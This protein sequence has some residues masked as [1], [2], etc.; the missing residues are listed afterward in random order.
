MRLFHKQDA[1]LLAGLSVA[2]VIIFS[3]SISRLLDYTREVER[4]HGLS[5]LPALVVLTGVFI[6]HQLRKRHEMV[7]Q[8][9]AAKAA[10]VE[11]E[12]RVQDLERLVAFGHALARA[13]N[14]DAIRAAVNQHLARLAGTDQVWVMLRQGSAWEAFTGDT[15]AAGDV[16]DREILADR[17]LGG[18]DMIAEKTDVV[19][20][21]LI[22][23]GTPI[24]VVGVNAP[25]GPLDPA[26]HRAIE[27]AGALL[28]VSL[29]NAQ[30]FEEVRNNSMRD[31][32]TGCVMR[33]HAAELIDVE[34]RRARRSQLPV[35][36]VMFDLDHFKQV[37]D[38]YGHLCGDAV[39]A[40]V[41]RC[42]REVLRGSD[43]KCRYGGEEFLVLLP[44]T[45]LSGAR[46]V[47]E[48][49]RREIEQ[50]PVVWAGQSLVCTAS[51]GVAQALPGET[52]IQAMVGRADA[53][54]YNAKQDGRNCVR[55]ATDPVPLPSDD[56]R[57]SVVA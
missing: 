22:V 14:H 51:F 15:R 24:G 50:R 42:M 38:K 7:A 16:I 23:G 37:N 20:F 25:E 21:P 54:L 9:T 41:G 30:L 1:F 53:A 49:L 40:A 52:S 33:T 27:A 57:P 3:P 47:A 39:L 28:G 29:K 19:G 18:A 8:A 4:E 46:R 5:L 13:L 32:L 48:T 45:P 10:Q 56:R 36:I 34:L 31:P 43:L 11:A 55:L 12:D 35:S 44:E 17:L 26:H 6:V 2:L